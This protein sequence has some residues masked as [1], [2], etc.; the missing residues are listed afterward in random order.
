[1]TPCGRHHRGL[2]CA[3]W[4]SSGQQ[5]TSLTSLLRNYTVLLPRDQHPSP[6]TRANTCK[7]KSSLRCVLHNTRPLRTRSHRSLPLP[8]VA[9]QRFNI[10]LVGT[11]AAS[12]L[13]IPTPG[14]SIQTELD[15]SREP[16]GQPI[17]KVAAAAE[18][19]L[20]S[21]VPSH[22]VL[23]FCL[24]F[25]VHGSGT[26]THFMDKRSNPECSLQP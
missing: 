6:A 12:L 20:Y 18:H 15:R 1:M 22:F 26:F 8:R 5:Q 4:A 23:V 2:L 7:S 9:T 25:S 24:L 21:V 11:R 10:T 16:S 13:S 17:G 14:V 3:S 19:L